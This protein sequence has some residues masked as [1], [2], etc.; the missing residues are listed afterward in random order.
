MATHSEWMDLLEPTLREVFTD[1]YMTKWSA[2]ILD[3][4]Y[5]YPTKPKTKLQRAIDNAVKE[6]ST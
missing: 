2:D 3:C 5:K 6:L 4:L 1:A